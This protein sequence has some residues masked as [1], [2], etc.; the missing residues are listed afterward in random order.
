MDKTQPAGGPMVKGASLIGFFKFVK[1][2]PKG[3]ALLEKVIAALPAASQEAC[4]RKIIAV[5]DYPYSIYVDFITA[6]DRVAGKGDL[7][8]CRKIGHY[9]GARDVGGFLKMSKQSPTPREL[10]IA[11]GALWKSYHLNSGYIKVESTEPESTVLRIYEFP[12]MAPAHCRLLEGYFAEGI[13]Q[14]GVVWVEEIR[15]TACMS[16]G[17]PYHE[18]K[19]KWK[20]A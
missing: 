18:F 9:A 15:E 16:R 10:A 14:A 7:A 5:A 6:V 13:K 12:A 8:L 2:G 20:M 4:R 3:D 17:A 11:A 19:G 1:E